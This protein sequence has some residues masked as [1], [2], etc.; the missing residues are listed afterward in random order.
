MHDCDCNL[1]E[2]YYSCIYGLIEL[3]YN[4]PI[5]YSDVYNN[6]NKLYFFAI[7]MILIECALASKN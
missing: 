4:Y 7:M 3:S 2:S 5:S 1:P 6:T